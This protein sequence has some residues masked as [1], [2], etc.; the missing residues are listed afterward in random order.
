MKRRHWFSTGIMTAALILPA[1]ADVIY[2]GFLDLSIPY[3]LA[4][5]TLTIDGGTLNAAF[6]GV[7]V[8]NNDLLQPVR[9]TTA[10][11][12]ALQNL[13]V[14]SVIDSSKTY[15]TG[16]GV[17][18]THLGNTFT[19]G[20]QGYIGFKV[21]ETDFGWA[22][23]VF[24]T[25]GSAK[26]KDWAYD[27]SGAINVGR[28]QQSA[29]VEGAQTVTLSPG[30]AESFTLGS[31]I[32]NTGGDIN[33]VVK[34][35]AGSTTLSVSNTYTGGTTVS[36]GT[37]VLSNASAAG[38]AGIAVSGGSSVL[39][40]SSAAPIGNAITVS[41]AGALVKR[42]LAISTA[43][44][45]GTTNALKSSFTSTAYLD[46]TAKILSGTSGAARNLEMSFSDS[47][48][49][50]NDVIRRSDVFTISGTATDAY[51]LQLTASG[52]A[53]DS[54]LG[55]LNGSSQWV[56]AGTTYFDTAYNNILTVGNYGFDSSTGSL[57]AVVNH[58][59]SFAA[60]PEPTSAVVGL[61]IGAGLLRRRRV[62]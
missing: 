37:L 41:N 40:I 3:N 21:N 27:T 9:A 2:S 6:G 42:D 25:D 47:S 52:L 4:G 8:Y 38:T 18:T 11:N 15:A 29:V 54:V 28:V 59:G 61:L 48:G 23:V 19:S 49:A 57:W 17:S 13:G 30:T 39:Q 24:A 31:Q 14:G 32:T 58:G 1:A 62:V 51:V 34:T 55:W 12:S 22:R 56:A 16:Y 10:G 44:D 45:V 33:S 60:V 5:V 50:G 26:I 43:Y 35:G 53:A 36:A 20:E 46:T 7:A